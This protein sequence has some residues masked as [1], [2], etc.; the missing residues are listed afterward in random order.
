[1]AVE[2]GPLRTAMDQALFH[3]MR[4]D[5]AKSR[6]QGAFVEYGFRRVPPLPER[7]APVHE[8]AHLLRDVRE[9]VLHEVREVALRSPNEQM[10][11]VRGEAEGEQLDIEAPNR[12]REYAAK[13]LV[14]PRRRTEQ[15]ASLEAPHGDKLQQTRFE[16]S[17]RPTH[18][19]PLFLRPRS[20]NRASPLRGV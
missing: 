4:D 5:V 19:N 13:D 15:Q 10:D 20:R 11:V 6:E 9:Q 8:C 16:S 12:T 2:P 18:R 14:R 7:P 17:Q 1:K 3:S